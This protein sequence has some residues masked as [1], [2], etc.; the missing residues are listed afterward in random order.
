MLAIISS[1]SGARSFILTPTICEYIRIGE[2]I[3]LAKNELAIS[4]HP[5]PNPNPEGSEH[6]SHMS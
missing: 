3:A 6:A 5:R 4:P 1:L 2:K